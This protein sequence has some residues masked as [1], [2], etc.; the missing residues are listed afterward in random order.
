M[1]NQVYTMEQLQE[2]WYAPEGP[3]NSDR[4]KETIAAADKEI[5]RLNEHLYKNG[6]Y[7]VFVFADGTTEDVARRVWELTKR[8]E[9]TGACLSRTEGV[10]GITYKLYFN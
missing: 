2:M 3:D 6:R 4:I 10:R 1:S 7:R 8:A 9:H 5:E